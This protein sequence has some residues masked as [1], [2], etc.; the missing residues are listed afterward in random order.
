[1]LT[2]IKKN[3]AFCFFERGAAFFIRTE[4]LIPRRFASKYVDSFARV[5]LFSEIIQRAEHTGER[6][7][8]DFVSGDHIFERFDVAARAKIDRRVKRIEVKDIVMRTEQ[9]LRPIV[10]TH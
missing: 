8:F 6:C 4:D 10:A 1:M 3:A 9:Q 2:V 5:K 7:A